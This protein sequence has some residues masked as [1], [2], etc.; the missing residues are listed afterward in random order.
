VCT[1]TTVIAV[2]V[3]VCIVIIVIGIVVV[4]YICARLDEYVVSVGLVY[5]TASFVETCESAI[6]IRIESR[7]ESFH[8]TPTNINYLNQ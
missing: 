5:R 1:E 6:C 4:A 8:A 7:I 3:V 2:S